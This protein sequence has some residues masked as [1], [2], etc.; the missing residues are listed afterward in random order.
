MKTATDLYLELMIKCLTNEIYGEEEYIPAVTNR[1]IGKFINACLSSVGLRFIKGRGFDSKKRE[2]GLDWP[3]Y[4]HTMIG[5][6]RLENILY[7]TKQILENSVP[8]DFIETG[9]WRGGSTIFMRAILKAYD[10]RDK[11]VWVADSFEGLPVP[12]EAAYPADKGDMHHTFDE[13]KVTM[14]S[15]KGNFHKYDLLDDQVKFLKGWF[16][17]TLPSAP[18]EK[19]SLV[20]L[21]GDMYESTMDAMVNLYPKLSP[22]GFLIVDDYCIEMCR[23]AITDYRAR[24]GI[25]DEIINIDGT[26]VFWQKS[27]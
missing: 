1:P 3:P 27:R 23:K 25:H 16:K 24:N 15:V 4:A 10:V 2:Y 13:L 26:G 11:R 9:V 19:L 22:G 20:R 6:K 7:C 12:N 14:D 21:D 17:D 8:G 18:I 5:R